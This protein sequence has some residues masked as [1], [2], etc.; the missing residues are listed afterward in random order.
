MPAIETT[1]THG[2]SAAP[3]AWACII[4]AAISGIAGRVAGLRV[5]EG[6]GRAAWTRASGVLD[7]DF[8]V[9]RSVG[10]STR[11]CSVIR[12]GGT[13]PMQQV[14]ALACREYGVEPCAHA[15]VAAGGVGVR[16]GALT[17]DVALP[18]LQTLWVIPRDRA[19]G[20]REEEG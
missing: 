2:C 12:A 1:S 3:F 15:L 7:R 13:V 10:P 11:Q 5:A 14:L 9:Y 8:R 19:G 17:R 16:A 18:G 20:V 4:G 6:H